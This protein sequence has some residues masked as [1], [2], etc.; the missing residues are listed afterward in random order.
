MAMDSGS[1]ATP[2]RL[3][4]RS[5][6][7][8]ELGRLAL[9][10]ARQAPHRS[11]G[12]HP[13]RPWPPEIVQQFLASCVGLLAAAR[14]AHR[15]FV[16]ARL[17]QIEATAGLGLIGLEN[18]L[19]EQTPPWR[20]TSEHLQALVPASAASGESAARGRPR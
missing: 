12:T 1:G 5:E 11:G 16:V 17:V 6:L 4:S 15:A 10:L 2:P 9:S 18:W 13:A 19:T 14:P 8:M 20:T 3:R 7:E